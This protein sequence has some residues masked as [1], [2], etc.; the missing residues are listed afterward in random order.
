M[1]ASIKSEMYDDDN[2]EWA[3][4]TASA[5]VKAGS[6]TPPSGADLDPDLDSGVMTT[7]DVGP[8]TIE[9]N[10][11]DSSGALRTLA[12]T[13]AQAPILSNGGK[14]KRGQRV[15]TTTK[16][17]SDEVSCLHRSDLSTPRA[18]TFFRFL[19]SMCMM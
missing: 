15:Y 4:A 9:S 1:H 19:V 17:A 10:D 2:D 16:R 6:E 13:A 7:V 8:F 14:R 11:D 18:H 3:S 12:V 5:P